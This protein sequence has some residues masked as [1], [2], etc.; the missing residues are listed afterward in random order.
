MSAK[1]TDNFSFN[2]L[3]IGLILGFA[4]AAFFIYNVDSDRASLE[5]C[6]SKL[7]RDRY[8]TMIAVPSEYELSLGEK[9]GG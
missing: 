3:C 8:C 9:D 1:E 2:S 6:N 4:V 7:E 5:S